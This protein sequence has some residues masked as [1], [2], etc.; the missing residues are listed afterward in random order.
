MSAAA[1]TFLR[2][3]STVSQ[4]GSPTS[5]KSEP[6]LSA[7][8]SPFLGASGQPSAG[9][10]GGSVIGGTRGARWGGAILRYLG[11]N[12]RLRKAL[13]HIG[14]VLLLGFYTAAGAAVHLLI[15]YPNSKQNTIS[16]HGNPELL[17]SH[18]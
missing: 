15:Y 6:I 4:P 14:L 7:T 18:T 5:L 13:A 17:L 9:T 16:L 8:G 11:S 2:L 10:G 1:N 3:N 12:P